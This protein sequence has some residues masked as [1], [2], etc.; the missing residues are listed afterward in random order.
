MRRVS[1]I[2]IIAAL[3]ATACTSSD[4]PTSDPPATRDLFADAP[5]ATDSVPPP[6]E[7]MISEAPEVTEAPEPVDFGIA[8]EQLGSRT[9]GG[10][11]TVPVDYSDP[12][13]GTIDL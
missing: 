7:P 9:D 5:V 12:G 11:L 6:T 8:W 13:A 3:A 2:L 4:D 1:A 10:W